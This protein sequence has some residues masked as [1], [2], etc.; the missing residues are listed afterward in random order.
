MISRP[1][2][3]LASAHIDELRR[4]AIRH[5][6]ARAAFPP[7]HGGRRSVRHRLESR[8]GSYLIKTGQRLL[9]SSTV[10]SGPTHKPNKAGPIR[11]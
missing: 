6:A 5:P 10:V 3:Q 7:R 1:A 2:E 4:Q 11:S 8:L 9:V